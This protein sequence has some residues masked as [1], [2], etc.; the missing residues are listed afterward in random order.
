MV[1]THHIDDQQ[2]VQKEI[3]PI[4]TTAALLTAAQDNI[5]QHATS[6]VHHDSVHQTAPPAYEEVDTQASSGAR[7]DEPATAHEI[8]SVVNDTASSEVQYNQVTFA[9]SSDDSAFANHSNDGYQLVFEHLAEE[10]HLEAEV[11]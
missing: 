7:R 2:P 11:S 5:D 3:P 9:E 8:D 4:V 1:D 6:K 10:Q